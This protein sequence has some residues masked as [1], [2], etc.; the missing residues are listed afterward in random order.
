LNSS[1]SIKNFNEREWIP[2]SEAALGT[3]YSA[4]Y[5]SLL[6]RKRKIPARKIKNVW[7]ITK[8]AL[9][10]YVKK[11]IVRT[12]IQNGGFSAEQ[13]SEISFPLKTAPKATSELTKTKKAKK[14]AKIA[15][16]YAPL[17]LSFIFIFSVFLHKT[18]LLSLTPINNLYQ[19]ISI[20]LNQIQGNVFLTSAVDWFRNIFGIKSQQLEQLAGGSNPD[21]GLAV[22]PETE[23]RIGIS[24]HIKSIFSDKVKINFDEEGDI[25][26]IV[27]VFKDKND[28]EDYSFVLVTIPISDQDLTVSTSSTPSATK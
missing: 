22:F 21:Y 5:L 11:Q 1:T 19:S 24:N 26:V 9:D 28:S 7:H 27:P 20:N 15:K 12:Y 8:Q 16:L 6:A 10:E 18:E 3:S 23:N 4:E 2:L 25:G 17:F 13:S 14:T